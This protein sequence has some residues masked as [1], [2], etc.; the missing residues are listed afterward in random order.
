M[1]GPC[2]QT[3]LILKHRVPEYVTKA[4]SLEIASKKSAEAY[5]HRYLPPLREV[6]VCVFQHDSDVLRRRTRSIHLFINL[7]LT[8]LVELQCRCIETCF[9]EDL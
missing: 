7:P 4:Q 5:F 6:C 1:E 2:S 3:G 9:S 8:L